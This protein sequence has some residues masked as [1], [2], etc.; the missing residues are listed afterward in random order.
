MRTALAAVALV[1]FGCA[2]GAGGAKPDPAPQ[3]GLETI[4]TDAGAY[5]MSEP[6]AIKRARGEV[7]AADSM[8]GGPDRALA[9]LRAAYEALGIPPTHTEASTGQVGNLM[10]TARRQLG[11]RAMSTYVGCGESM[12]GKRA[13]SDR[14]YLSIVSTARA[15][16][17]SATLVTTRLDASAVDVGGQSGARQP[18]ASTGVLE[19]RV[20]KLARDL[21]AAR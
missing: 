13:D 18:C 4:A 19:A 3:P 12:T 10:F 5:L 2:G 14:I 20:N 17:S 9:A 1:A 7:A 15:A 8:P 21:L 16:G 6:G 11:G